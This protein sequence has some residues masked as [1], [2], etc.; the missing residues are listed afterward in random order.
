MINPFD[1]DWPDRYRWLTFDQRCALGFLTMILSVFG[2]IGIII[3]CI[4]LCISGYGWYVAGAGF[5]VVAFFFGRFFYGIYKQY[6]RHYPKP[7][8]DI[9][10]QKRRSLNDLT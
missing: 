3:G 7:Q 10:E 9:L 1:P 4:G 2:I 8:R 5:L 6:R